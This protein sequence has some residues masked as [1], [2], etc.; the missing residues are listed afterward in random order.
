MSRLIRFICLML[1]LCQPPDCDAQ[2]RRDREG[3]LPLRSELWQQ[4]YRQAKQERDVENPLVDA[5]AS[6]TAGQNAGQTTVSPD[7]HVPSA[8][9]LAIPGQARLEDLQQETPIAEWQ[10]DQQLAAEDRAGNYRD[11]PSAW[12]L[13]K[14]SGGELPVA[15]LSK[16]P[17]ATTYL[18]GFMACIVVCGALMTGRES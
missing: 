18:V 14:S 10:V 1:L 13:S 12:Q 15:E 7:S 11:A 4:E 16:G 5:A 3:A 2:S 17:T 8:D 9:S 6:A